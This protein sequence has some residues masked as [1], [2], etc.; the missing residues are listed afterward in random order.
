VAATVVLASNFPVFSSVARIESPSVVGIWMTLKWDRPTLLSSA[1]GSVSMLEAHEL[2][3]LK[4]LS[5][6]DG[7]RDT[8]TAFIAGQDLFKVGRMAGSGDRRQ[9]FG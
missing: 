8:K 2:N 1:E 5:Q 3:R 7:P 9:E 4:F 6:D